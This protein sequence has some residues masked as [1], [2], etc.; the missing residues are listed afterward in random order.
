MRQQHNEILG[1]AGKIAEIIRS[2]R[3][4]QEATTIRNALNTFGGKLTVHLAME[5]KAV[6]PALARHADPRVRQ[7]AQ[8]YATEMGGLV[9]TVKDYLAHWQAKRI[10]ADPQGFAQA[11]QGVFSALAARVA[12]ENKELYPLVDQA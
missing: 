11:T 12:A 8:K 1:I 2:G 10:E 4:A 9:N 3:T 7:V 5:D 6:Y